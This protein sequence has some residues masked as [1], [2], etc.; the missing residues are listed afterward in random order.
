MSENDPLEGVAVIGFAGR[1]PRAANIEQYW[2]NL[3][4]GMDC[5]S[6]F[7]VED[8]VRE[9]VPLEVAR[10]PDYIRRCPVVENPSGFD[11]RLFRYSPK[12]AELI[13]P[14]QRILLECSWEAL[15]H[16]G[17]DPHRF[18]G[19]IGIWAGTGLNNYFLKNII[20]RGSFEETA[21]SQTIINND[22]DY[23]ASR[24]AYKMNLRGPAVVVQTACS[25]S[26]VAVST[27]CQ[28]LLTYQ[29]DMALAGASFLQTPRA[30]GYLYHE[31]D[32]FSPDGYCRAFDKAANGT[33]LGE[34][35]GLVVLRRLA[36][37]V[38]D[39]DN[40][41]A[42]IRGYAINNDGAARAGYTAPGVTGQMELVTTAMAMAGVRAEELSYIEAHGT[43]TQ[44]GD[45]IEVAALTQAFKRSTDERGFCGLGSVKNNIGHLDVA[46][47]IAGLIKTICALQHRQLPPTINIEE[48]NPELRLEESPFYIVDRLTDW[49]QPRHGNRIAGVSSF[50]MGGTNAHVVL[51]EYTGRQKTAP[52]SR[53]WHLL[54][55]S[56]ATATAL[57]TAAGNISRYLE[58]ETDISIADAAWT[59]AAG[60]IP[61]R[62]R[63]C[64]IAESSASAARI[65]SEP[66][67]LYATDGEAT[68]DRRP[69]VFLFSGQGTQYPGMGI[70]LYRNEPVFRNAML[71]CSRLIGPVAGHDS[72]TDILYSQ[73]EET[74][75]LVNQ[76]AISQVALF[77]FEYSM[78]RL[79]ESYGVKPSGLVGHSIGEYVA[80]CEAGVFSLEDAIILVKERGRLMQSMQDGT[81]IAIPLPEK[82]VRE[83]LPEVLD[84]AVVNGPNISIVSGARGDM[85]MFEN[86]LE[87][88]GIMFRR[89]VTSHAFHSRLMEPAAQTFAEVVRKVKMAPPKLPMTSNL[90]GSWMSAEQIADP[91]S[92][93]DHLRHTVRFGDNLAAV[94]ERFASPVLVEVGPGNTLCTIAR[95]HD[96]AV[97]GLAGIPCARHPHQTASDRV[98]FFRALGSL[99]C[100]GA[101]IDLCTLYADEKRMRIPLPGYPFERQ[102][103]W[104]GGQ[105]VRQAEEE[106]PKRTWWKGFQGLH[107][108]FISSARKQNE[109]R[110]ITE[111]DLISIWCK[112]L[113]TSTI[114]V[115]ENF[116]E[117]GGHSLLAVSIITEL[118]KNFGIRLPL[119]SLIEAPT[120]REFLRLI[121]K[122]KSG[123]STSYLVPLNTKGSKP[124]FF[125]MHSHGGNILEYHPLANLLKENRPVY[126]IQ[127]RGLD[128]SPIE[129][130][131]VEEMARE[132]LDVIRGVQPRGPYYLGGYCFGGYLSLELAHLLRA[133]NEEVKILVLINSATHLFNIYVPGITK[134]QRI[135]YSFRDRA[136]LEWSEL[137]GQPFRKKI[138]RLIMRAERIRDLTQNKIEIMLDRLPEGS[139]F[140]IRKHSLVYHLEQIAD[141]NDRAWARYR[142]KPYDGKVLFLRAQK[143]PLG[144]VPDPLLGWSNLLTGELHVHE[145]PEFRQNMLDEPNVSEV[146]RIILEHL[147]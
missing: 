57:K 143:Q 65:L 48:L 55:V 15:E 14:Q 45:P 82:T 80:A 109:E 116:F 126:A 142:P 34:G 125:L 146:A 13:D 75:N 107:F 94:A 43:G 99:W 93:A 30:R 72:L 136:A 69:L 4:A 76:T 129:E 108:P 114:G 81:M 130:Q 10:R 117:L 67:A 88:K 141:A 132:Y 79:L 33:V 2:A 36:D 100:H 103:F 50:G 128:G 77:A 39:G 54:P 3:T 98:F 46:A 85:E 91:K 119:A 89:L 23:A 106:K 101:A 63:R 131:D 31:G 29:C 56:A 17:Y 115:N 137:S 83:M 95:Q 18:P 42:V 84:L 24:I 41:L 22:K 28:A 60:R 37:A 59:L 140:R 27:A 96:E 32:I 121:E 111:E 113:G 145:V 62:H 64:V 139:P 49:P 47:G 38:D 133:D 78:T 134:V 122:W 52:S 6:E 53:Q 19:L 87:E 70:E 26:L 20:S 51:E 74:G 118:E 7:T 112:A 71:E 90:T 44:L 144:L 1:F 97:S 138:Q 68:Q 40:I 25:T 9:G 66:N 61:L 21:V 5:F 123:A 86:R 35:C 110:S 135:W 124:P 73:N 58:N 8:I 16:A 11:A 102:P 120:I 127:C 147:P 105:E 92:W 104:I 12:E